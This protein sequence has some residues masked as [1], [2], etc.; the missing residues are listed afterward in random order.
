MRSFSLV[1]L[2]CALLSWSWTAHA[3]GKTVRIEITGESLPAALEITDPDIVG[4][5]LV[6]TGPGVQINGRSAHTDPQ[7]QEGAFIDWPAGKIE[8]RPGGLQHFVVSFYV[9][10]NPEPDRGKL[11]YVVAYEFDPATPGGYVYLPTSDDM[12]YPTARVNVASIYHG[13]EGNWFRSSARWEE[14]VRPVIEKAAR[15]ERQQR[16]V[17][18]EVQQARRGAA[19]P[20]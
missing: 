17:D 19:A 11:A 4:K 16:P 3:K 6:W 18:P 8:E 15:P 9:Q 1:M 2:L 7:H 5:F 13:V 14:L 10:N 12:S 20:G